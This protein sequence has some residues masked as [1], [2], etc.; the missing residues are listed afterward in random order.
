MLLIAT[1]LAILIFFEVGLNN[2]NMKINLFKWI[3][4]EILN[5]NMCFNFDSLTVLC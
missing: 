1:I 3:D 4:S 2:I 5:I